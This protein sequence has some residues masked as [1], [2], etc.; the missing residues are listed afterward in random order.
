M[1]KKLDAYRLAIR[2][3]RLV[4]KV[5]GDVQRFDSNLASQLRRAATSVP[6]NLAEGLRRRGRDRA[7]LLTVAQGSAAEVQAILD[8]SVAME[9]INTD[10]VAE[11]EQVIDRVCAMLQ[12]L[13]G[14]AAA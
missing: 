11:L 3:V 7:H 9:V 12:R 14:R 10:Q 2:L 13:R 4:R 1:F 6:L 8:V 5:L